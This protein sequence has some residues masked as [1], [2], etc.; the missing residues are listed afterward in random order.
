MLTAAEKSK[1]QNRE[2]CALAL[3]IQSLTI[4]RF[5]THPEL[6][7]PEN[8][9]KDTMSELEKMKDT[10]EKMEQERAAMVAEV[11]AQIERALASMAVGIDHS[12]E[13]DDLDSRPLSRLSS[14]SGR[15][16]SRRPSDTARPFRS[17]GTES[18]L[19]ESYDD[20]KDDT[21]VVGTI[22][23][24]TETIV[25]D[26]EGEEAVPSPKKR[27]S[28][29]EV[30]LPQDGMNAV[31]EGIGQKSDKICTRDSAQGQRIVCFTKFLA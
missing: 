21:L 17:F 24:G 15:T 25:E 1:L 20:G 3:C 19:T 18:T 23:R 12:E 2:L 30:D 8:A 27:F 31:D 5:I 9:H 28:A 10:T 29:T 16:R 4:L 11:E 26:E 22:E 14:V 7:D 6:R 13:G